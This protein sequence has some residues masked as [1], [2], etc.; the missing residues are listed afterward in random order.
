MA[1]TGSSSP[2]SSPASSPSD[3]RQRLT[4]ARRT[5]ARAILARRRLLCALCVAGAVFATVRALAPTPPPT[6]PV[7]VA[8]HDLP[9]GAVLTAGDLT[10]VELPAAAAPDK[11]TSTSYAVGRTTTGPVRRGEPMT[12]VRLVGAGLLDG[13]PGLVAVPVRVPDDGA[14]ALLRVGDRIDLLA[15]DQR[16]G[17]TDRVG[18]DVPVIALPREGPDSQATGASG[19]LIVVGSTPET[20][21]IVAASAATRYLTATISR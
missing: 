9:A 6:V 12:D 2:A 1:R 18:D 13:Y 14:A 20:A 7:T 8:A 4:D 10:T 11:V 17:Q 16:T 19:R 5:V 21:E 3:L 15:T